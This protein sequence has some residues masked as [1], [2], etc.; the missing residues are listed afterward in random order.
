MFGIS[1]TLDKPTQLLLEEQRAY[2]SIDE[3]SA[4]QQE[5]LDGVNFKLS[6]LG[7]RF[8][9][10]DDEYSRFLRMRNIALQEKF[11][12]ELPQELAENAVSLSRSERED[13]AKR[14][15]ENLV[16]GSDNKR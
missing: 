16:E 9:H 13:L 4:E 12:T 14:L 6:R 1:S 10:P 5:Q 11:N 3:L 7:F 2:S 8:F 15:V